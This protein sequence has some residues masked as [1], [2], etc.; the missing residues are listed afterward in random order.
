M[1]FDITLYLFVTFVTLFVIKINVLKKKLILR[2]T[3][4]T[5]TGK[6]RTDQIKKLV[7]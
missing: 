7:I 5:L 6:N 4:K 1:N 2:T 3:E